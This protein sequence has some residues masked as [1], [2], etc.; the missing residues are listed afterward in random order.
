[1]L[2]KALKSCPKSNNSPDLVTL[3]ASSLG[4][5]RKRDSKRCWKVKTGSTCCRGADVGERQRER[6]GEYRNRRCTERDEGRL[7]RDSLN[8][9]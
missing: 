7:K 9:S 2:P 3:A 4:R 5:E 8:L 6:E 1:M